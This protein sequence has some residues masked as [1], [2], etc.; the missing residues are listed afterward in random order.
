MKKEIEFLCIV[1]MQH[2]IAQLEQEPPHDQ[3]TE[4]EDQPTWPRLVFVN[5]FNNVN[6]SL[7][8]KNMNL[9]NKSRME[10]GEHSQGSTHTEECE[11]C[12]RASKCQ[13]PGVSK[14]A[15]S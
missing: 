8:K 7:E 5:V 6:L 14:S 11:R 4:N 12:R 15:P 1:L 3:G 9:T 2:R 13:T 10:V